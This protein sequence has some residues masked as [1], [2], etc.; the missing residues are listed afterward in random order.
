MVNSNDVV[1]WGYLLDPCFQF[2][3]TAGK[4]L[5]EGYIEVYIAGTR[6]KYYCASDFDGTLHPFQIPLDSLGANIVLAD[7]DQAYDVYVYNKFGSL[8][9]SR[10]NVSPGNAG[11]AV[12]S[13]ISITSSDNTINITH[14]GNNYDLSIQDTIDRLDNLENLVSGITGET[15]YVISTGYG[16][17]GTFVLT[18]KEDKGIQYLQDMSGWR[19][20][21]GHIYQ[22]NFNS[23]FTLDDNYNTLVEGKL[24]L[25]G[26]MSFSQDWSYSL[27]DSFDHIKHING[28]TVIAVPT[29]LQYYDLKLKYTF[30]SV[31]NCQVDLE[32]I[33]L[34]DITSIVLNNG[35]SGSDY[36][37]GDGININS[38]N[39]ISVDMDYINNQIDI[40]SKLSSAINIANQYTDNSIE[41]VIALV[42]G[43]TGEIHQVNSDWEATSGVAEILHKPDL[44]IYAT[45]QEVINSVSAA[46]AVLEQEI[47]DIPEQV[48]SDWTQTNASA[49]DYIKN[50]PEEEAVEF[51]DLVAG[52]NIS[53]TASGSS[54]VI[55][56][57]VDLTNY[58]THNEV[59]SATTSAVSSAN[60]YTDTAI[61]NIDLSDY[62]THTEVYNATSS[63]VT[64]A[65]SYTDTAI[66]NIDLTPAVEIV[67]PNSS[68][69]VSSVTDSV[70]NTKTFY[71][72][73]NN[74]ET[75]YWIGEANL[76]LSD[77][78]SQGQV[79]YYKDV[80]DY[81][82][83]I[84]GNLDATKLKKGLYLLTANVMIVADEVNN[85]LAEI[86]I[87]SDSTSAIS[88]T[89]SVFQHDCSVADTLGEPMDE[90]HQIATIVRVMYDDTPMSLI[91]RLDDPTTVSNELHLWFSDIGLYELQG[92]SAGGGSSP[93]ASGSY[94]AGWGIVINGNVIS[95]N[96]NIIPDISNLAS[97]TYVDNR[98]A[99][100]I[101][102]V[103]GEIPDVSDMATK[104]WVNNQG[105]LTEQV[106]SD[107]T[108]YNQDDPAYI[109]NKPLEANLVAG[110]NI[111]ITAS[112]NNIIISS[113]A[114]A[115]SGTQ[116]QAGTGIDITGDV[117]SVDNTVAMKTDIPD[118]TSYVTSSQVSAIVEAATGDIPTQVQSDW[119][120]TASGSVDFIK[121]KP[122]TE[123]ITV[124][125][126]VAG[127][128][129]TI[130]ASGDN[131][132]ISSTGGSSGTSYSAGTGIDIT[133]NTISIDNTVALKTDIPDVSSYITSTQASAI[134]GA[135]SSVIENDIPD[136]SDMAT[137]TWVGQQGYLTSI[138]STYATDTEVSNAI[139]S[140]VSGMATQSWVTS[141]GYLTSVPSTYATDAEVSAAIATA[142]ASV[143]AQVQ[144]N[145]TESASASPAYIQNKP[146]EVSVDFCPI[147]AGSN[148]T[149]TASGDS[150]VISS[151]GGGG[152]STYTEG[153]GIDITSD[154]ISID[155]SVVA[156]KTWVG[157][158]GYLTS[159][160]SQ[161]ITETELSS[162]LSTYALK[163][164][165]PDPVSGASG[166]KVEDS[167]V[168]LDNP[169][170][171][172]AG[173]NITITV[174]GDSAIIAGQAGGGSSYTAGTGID[175]TN[176]V[177]SVTDPNNVFIAEYGVTTN[178]QISSAANAG[179]V[180][181]CKYNDLPMGT[182][183]LPAVRGADSMGYYGE[184]IFQ[185]EIY[186]NSTPKLLQLKCDD[187]GWSAS[188]LAYDPLQVQA[189]WNESNG[190]S[191]AYIRNKPDLS[192]FVTSTTVSAIAEAEVASVETLAIDVCPIIAGQNVT[193]TA[194]GSSAVI[195]A[196]VDTS[197][198]AT[199]AELQTVSAAIPDTSDMATQTW[200]CNQGY[201]TSIPST[202]ATDVEVTQAVTG[203]TQNMVS[204]TGNT[205]INHIQLVSSLPASPDANTLYLIPEA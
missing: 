200:V 65:N 13:N 168:S 160:P 29:T 23:K 39:Y 93:S 133:N 82:T 136:T 142:I 16:D 135:V 11:G 125:T 152:G 85:D 121:N 197:T 179:K 175:I 55:S 37:A 71:I 68:I 89:S 42:S 201:L 195:D 35:G 53:I 54:T 138:P 162:E 22:L 202:Y 3:N 40:D 59:Y 171:L 185:G 127:N 18:D 117:I 157:N 107:W 45:H 57:N 119:A 15:D 116:Y 87:V 7:P 153:T 112:G 158:Q 105:Y 191:K 145:W 183:Y 156:T 95:V 186:N 9:M 198:L 64:A 66:S 164:D 123:A 20:K 163:T 50:K 104:T 188:E 147:I 134:V 79:G 24:Y 76:I 177:I 100:A 77:Q 103:E 139:A 60:S 94:D 166:V 126:L 72:D 83:R 69:S 74:P 14:T 63:A 61:A 130:T 204:Y 193:I 173:E 12:A 48:Q 111:S 199:K 78:S 108:E 184:P 38:S 189:N 84:N 113:T 128:N 25:D 28:S 62:S 26:D 98:I 44:S 115:A 8:Q 178:S 174:S 90:S 149:I 124:S 75:N 180:V 92:T 102:I 144:S 47:Q 114:S 88:Y 67:S 129:I 33:S 81:T 141:Q 143:P 137:M 167:I 43:V 132:V 27:D 170:G 34:V 17:S 19:L 70:N 86:Q 30:N 41:E 140:A 51:T 99:S 176:N 192:S 31:V 182:V 172:V 96:Q 159:V 151:T 52:N 194:S 122:E 73:T 49:V 148:I 205:A 46:T 58:A 110:N 4:P 91:A 2:Q 32:N 203:A 150:A 101:D 187:M 10:Y 190:S 155:D 6:D 196:T 1:K 5:T 118:V 131:V 21:P 56:A 106:Q 120:Q 36:H 146:T 80:F 181:V 161:Y 109:K 154:V 97:T 165:I 169:V